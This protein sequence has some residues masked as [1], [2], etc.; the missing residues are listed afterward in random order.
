MLWSGRG[1]WNINYDVCVECG[2]NIYKYKA[3]GLCRKCYRRLHYE[4]NR[5]HEL[6][7]ATK[8]ETKHQKRRN[9]Y[10]SARRSEAR[11]FIKK[12]NTGEIPMTPK[13]EN[14][15]KAIEKR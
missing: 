14:L 5:K 3:N 7:R 12:A 8:W 1:V 6:E 13:I 9:E 15:L 4:N 2:Q 10:K 11:T